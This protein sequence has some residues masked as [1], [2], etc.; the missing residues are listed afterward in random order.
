VNNAAGGANVL[1]D[2]TG[3]GPRFDILVLE[4]GDHEIVRLTT[5]I[6]PDMRGLE[7]QQSPPKREHEYELIYDPNLK[8]ADLWIDGER[9]I[10][11]YRGHSQYLEDRGLLFGAIVYKSDSGYASF[12]TVRFEVNP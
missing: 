7:I 11:N 9:R 10:T 1:A 2:F 3:V 5:Q 8:S 12:K 6:I 4:D